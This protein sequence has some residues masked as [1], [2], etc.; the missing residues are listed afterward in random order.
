MPRIIAKSKLL[1][2]SSGNEEEKDWNP[3]ASKTRERDTVVIKES[4][5]TTSIYLMIS[6][7]VFRRTGW[8]GSFPK[9]SVYHNLYGI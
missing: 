1:K 3:A 8:M 6:S 7:T 5:R 2:N 4:I 9:R